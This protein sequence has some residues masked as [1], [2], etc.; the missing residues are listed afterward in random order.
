MGEWMDGPT[1]LGRQTCLQYQGKFIKSREL[2]I[3]HLLKMEAIFQSK[4]DTEERSM[5][6]F[7][8]DL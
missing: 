4:G 5:R 3:T 6:H 1:L 2:E 7:R 8:G